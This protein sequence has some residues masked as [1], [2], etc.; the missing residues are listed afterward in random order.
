MTK[1]TILA[2]FKSVRWRTIVLVYH[3]ESLIRCVGEDLVKHK[4][5]DRVFLEPATGKIAAIAH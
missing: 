5:D 4:R 3:R 2:G 1:R